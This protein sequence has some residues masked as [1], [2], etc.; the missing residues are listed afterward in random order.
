MGLLGFRSHWIAIVSSLWM[1]VFCF[2]ARGEG[3][4]P[5]IETQAKARQISGYLGVGYSRLGFSTGTSV[6]A[7]T[8]NGG[9]VYGFT[10]SIGVDLGLAQGFSTSSGFSSVFISGSLQVVWAVTGSVILEQNATVMDHTE[11]LVSR[12]RLSPS[13]K[14]QFGLS[15][16]ILTG[17]S[18]SVTFAGYGAK[19]RYELPSDEKSLRYYMDVGM[20]QLSNGVTTVN[21]MKATG[22]V[23]I[24]F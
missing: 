4:E 12:E 21:A 18:S 24:W 19:I 1:G 11:V 16:Y 17:S 13:L 15:D 22:G 7:V 2:T 14:I 10:R 9:L 3:S 23:L 5:K 8:V 6:N 20:D